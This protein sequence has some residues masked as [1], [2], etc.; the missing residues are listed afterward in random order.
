MFSGSGDS[1][2]RCDGGGRGAVF[3]DTIEEKVVLSWEDH[4]QSFGWLDVLV[5]TEKL[6]QVLVE[7]GNFHICLEKGYYGHNA[8]VLRL[9][10]MN[11][12]YVSL[13]LKY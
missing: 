11:I 10:D 12:E 7:D 4:L 3:K 9:L 13:A 6:I 2:F 8:H 5:M 1:T